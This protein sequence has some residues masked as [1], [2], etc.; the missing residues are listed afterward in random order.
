MLN[1][2]SDTKCRKLTRED[3]PYRTDIGFH[4]KD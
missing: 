1:Y 3:F 4:F 2:H